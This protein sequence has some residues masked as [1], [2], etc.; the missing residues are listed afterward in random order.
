[1]TGHIYFT[2]SIN[3]FA[4]HQQP[5]EQPCPQARGRRW[6]PHAEALAGFVQLPSF[7]D[8][9]CYESLF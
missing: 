5:G 7:S 8:M 3:V 1:M 4:A 6:Q 9:Q 2:W